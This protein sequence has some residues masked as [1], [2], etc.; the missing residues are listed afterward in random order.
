MVDA[1]D[2]G[3]L[4]NE[5]RN[6]KAGPDGNKGNDERTR[7]G[8]EFVV[9][10]GF[11]DAREEVGW[12]RQK[13]DELRDEALRAAVVPTAG[14]GEIARSREKN[15]NE[16]AFDGVQKSVPHDVEIPKWSSSILNRHTGERI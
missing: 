12:Q 1:L 4:G 11:R 6:R 7:E 5:K 10:E 14:G 9:R 15:Q 2:A 3:D 16:D 8:E 13:G